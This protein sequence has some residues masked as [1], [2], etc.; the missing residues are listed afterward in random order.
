MRTVIVVAARAIARSGT[1]PRPPVRRPVQSPGHG[2][3]TDLPP[4]RTERTGGRYR[5]TVR[6]CAPFSHRRRG[7][8]ARH[9]R[10]RARARGENMRSPASMLVL[11]V[12]L[13]PA[14]AH[15]TFAQTPSASQK[16]FGTARQALDGATVSYTHLTLP[17]SDLV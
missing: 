12:S 7:M 15:T 6:R 13:L 10:P 1:R 16:A 4:V 3:S 9:R 11:V 5:T 14:A 2:K 8:L 17:T